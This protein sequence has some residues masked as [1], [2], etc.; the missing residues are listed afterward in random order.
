[1]ISLP[2][3]LNEESHKI[4]THDFSRA[5]ADKFGLITDCAIHQPTDK[6]VSSGADLRNFHA[7]ILLTIY[8]AELDASGMVSLTTKSDCELSDTDRDK[9]GLTRAKDEV[10]EIREL[11]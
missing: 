8:K 11:W 7:H 2:H 10:T 1:M 6:E 5:L 9:K 3:E 4:L